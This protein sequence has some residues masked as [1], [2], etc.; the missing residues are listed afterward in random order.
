MEYSHI[1]HLENLKTLKT[2]K[3]DIPV[4]DYP[5]CD[6]KAL[7]ENIKNYDCKSSIEPYV[8]NKEMYSIVKAY[9]FLNKEETEKTHYEHGEV[10]EIVCIS[11]FKFD[12]ETLEP[13]RIY[14]K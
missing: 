3:H 5:I 11:I 6:N 2:D 8:C 10:Y 14:W 9:Y 4:K 1:Y 12:K 7:I 13:E